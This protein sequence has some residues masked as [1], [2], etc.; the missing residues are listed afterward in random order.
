M[1]KLIINDRDVTVSLSAVEKL[2]ALHGNVVVPRSAVAQVRTVLNGMVEV[3]GLRAPGTGLPGVIKVG[4]WRS[5]EGTTF[6][7]CHGCRSAIVLDLVGAPYDRLVV[8]LDDPDHAIRSL[9]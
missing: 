7:V 5:R 9:A 3:H 6:G 2:E 1:A 4:T 8:T